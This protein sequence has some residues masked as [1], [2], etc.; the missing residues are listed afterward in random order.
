MTSLRIEVEQAM[1]LRFPERNGEAVVR[2]EESM[3]IPRAAENLMRGFYRN[4]DRVRQYFQNVH[5]RAAALVDMLLPHRSRLHEWANQL[6]ERPQEAER[7]LKDM[8]EELAKYQ[9]QYGDITGELMRE[10][11]ES[12]V[13]DM[14]P[15]SLGAFAL[16]SYREPQVRVFL[17]PIGRLAEI[18]QLNPEQLRQTVRVH[19][20]FWLLLVSGVDLDN[21]KYARGT[22]DHFVHQ[23]CGLYAIRFLRRKSGE[24]VKCYQEWLK[25]W[26]FTN[27]SIIARPEGA[28][29]IRAAMV[30][31]RRQ[32]DLCWDQ[33][34]EIANQFELGLNKDLSDLD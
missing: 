1:G 25:A 23:V 22:E 28:E 16:C 14:F 19:F 20:L 3:E 33:A 4:P 5:D 27:L 15:L 17:R 24:L 26:G 7:Y 9:R 11:E 12:K 8:S 31:W 10:L 32:K 34:L 13:E 21:E 2:F 6:P 18:R 30:F 29:K